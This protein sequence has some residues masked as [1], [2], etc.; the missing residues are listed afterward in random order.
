MTAPPDPGDRGRLTIHDRVV[1]RIAEQAAVE[2]GG[3]RERG[4]LV[5]GFGGRPLPRASARVVGRHVRLDLVVGSRLDASLPEAAAEIRTAV[6]SRVGELTG[7]TVDDVDIRVSRFADTTPSTG[8]DVLPAAARPAAPG[9]ARKAGLLLALLLL[10]VAGVAIHAALAGLDL[11]GGQSLV[12]RAVRWVDGLRP[13]DWMLPAGV[14]LMVVGVL[15]VA[16]AVWRRP[17]RSLELVSST[18]VYA[19]RRAIEAVAVDAAGRHP[20]VVT[21]RARARRG[22]VVVRIGTDGDPGIDADVAP[23]I[24]ARLERLAGSPDIRVPVSR[25]G[26]ER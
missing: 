17:R 20:D 1:A 18:G 25:A 4:G 11:V 21:A 10:G 24:G 26:G 5:P 19:S 13:Q 8:A 23:D 3:W 9:V 2:A 22:H 12:D 14:A 7:L 15:L 16:A 6:H